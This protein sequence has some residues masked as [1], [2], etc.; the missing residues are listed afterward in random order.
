QARCIRSCRMII[1]EHEAMYGSNRPAVESFEHGSPSITP[2]A[3]GN[4][5]LSRLLSALRA[6]EAGDFT[7]RLSEQG[8][9]VMD[10]IVGAFNGIASLNEQLT[11]QIVRLSTSEELRAVNE[12][13]HERQR[14]LE[15]A[16]RA[17]GRFYASMSHELRTP[18]HAILGYSALLL[19]KVYGSLN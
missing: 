16:I 15:D 9:P 4:A 5:A 19:D 7:V 11:H 1:P 12:Q 8:D 3:D 18:I 14:E 17:R 10:E 13:L 6:L 2:N